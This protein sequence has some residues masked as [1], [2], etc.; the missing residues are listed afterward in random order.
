MLVT[1]R[2]PGWAASGMT[3]STNSAAATRRLVSRSKSSI[4]FDTSSTRLISTSQTRS[5]A[6]AAVAARNESTPTRFISTV[7]MSLVAPAVTMRAL[8]PSST[9]IWPSASSRPAAAK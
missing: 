2:S 9:V 7:G 1:L 5:S 4:E 6:R 3:C 8:R